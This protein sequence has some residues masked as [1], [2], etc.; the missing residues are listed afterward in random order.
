M[1]MDDYYTS[2][3]LVKYI[4]YEN[5]NL[6]ST[7]KGDIHKYCCSQSKRVT[8]KLFKRFYLPT[9]FVHCVVRNSLIRFE[10]KE[11]NIHS[12]KILSKARLISNVSKSLS[13]FFIVWL[14]ALEQS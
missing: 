13:S 6:L 4:P 8:R 3:Q 1:L 14:C 7:D 2:F 12:K 11:S 9:M 10:H 5:H